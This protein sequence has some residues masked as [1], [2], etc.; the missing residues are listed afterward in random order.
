MAILSFS[1]GS[2]Q[3][4][5]YSMLFCDLTMESNPI[6]YLFSRLIILFC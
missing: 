3:K 4:Y 2:A 5:Q 6:K 1:M